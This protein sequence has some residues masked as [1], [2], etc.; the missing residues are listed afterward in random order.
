VVFEMIDGIQ[1]YMERRD[2]RRLEE[3]RGKVKLSRPA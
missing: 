3:I 2:I 1:S